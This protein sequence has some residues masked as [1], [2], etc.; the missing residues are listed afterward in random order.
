MFE[1]AIVK[2]DLRM[3]L[4]LLMKNLPKDLRGKTAADI[5]KFC[6]QEKTIPVNLNVILKKLDISAKKIDFT[7]IEALLR[8]AGQISDSTR[9][10]GAAVSKE[11]QRAIFYSSDPGLMSNHRYRFTVAHELAHLCQGEDNHIEFRSDS[12]I[13]DHNE[14]SANIFAG[15]LL[16]PE[17]QL[18]KISSELFLPTTKNLSKVFEVSERVMIARLKHLGRQDLYI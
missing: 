10:L 14:R 4:Y 11:G 5:L 13:D 2:T 1:K 18:E 7:S 3:C 12:D 15:E 9:I 16:M 17:Q 6:G 8:D